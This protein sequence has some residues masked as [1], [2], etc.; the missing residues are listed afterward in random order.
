MGWGGRPARELKALVI[1]TYG[2]RCC[3]CHQPVDLRRRFPDRWSASVEHLVPRSKGGSD[4][5]ENLRLAHLGCNSSRGNR[6]RIQ[7]RRLVVDPS[8]RNLF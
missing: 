4:D 2:T 7:R 1:A 5:L 6:P 8:V 3:L